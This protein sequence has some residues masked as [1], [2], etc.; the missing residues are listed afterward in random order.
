MCPHL[1]FDPSLCSLTT[2]QTVVVIVAEL[3]RLWVFLHR[4]QIVPS[5]FH[6]LSSQ[7]PTT[8]DLTDMKHS[9]SAHWRWWHMNFSAHEEEI[10]ADAWKFT[11]QVE[12]F[13]AACSQH[14]FYFIWL[15]QYCIR[16]Y[17]HAS[18]KWFN[19]SLQLS[20]Y[21]S[22]YIE[23]FKIE[24]TTLYT[25]KTCLLLLGSYFCS[26]ALVLLHQSNFWDLATSVQQSL[27]EQKTEA[28]KL[29]DWL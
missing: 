17:R 23:L 6:P 1:T 16:K 4:L 11:A 15:I 21:R 14:S 10:L 13:I 19:Q 8:S 12:R 9:P 5:S 29:S 18:L 25:I 20:K 22:I 2:Q 24:G 3:R 7:S 26:V 27:T 28:V